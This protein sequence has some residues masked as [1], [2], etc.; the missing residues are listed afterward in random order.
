[1]FEYIQ[2]QCLWF[3]SQDCSRGDQSTGARGSRREGGRRPHLLC[4]PDCAQGHGS[5]GETERLISV[6]D[7]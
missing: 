3:C 6:F 7:W 5:P 1:M 2:T 4:P